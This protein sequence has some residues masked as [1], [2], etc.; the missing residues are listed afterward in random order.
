[1]S[2]PHLDDGLPAD[3]LSRVL[4][5]GGQPLLLMPDYC[6]ATLPGRA[7]ICWKDT[8]ASARAVTAALPLLLRA[9]QVLLV[10]VDEGAGFAEA[11]IEAM[12]HRLG[13]HG[14]TAECLR[15]SHTGQPVMDAL[16]HSA[17]EHHADLL[18]MGCYGHGALRRLLLGGC[19][20]SVLDHA[21]LP[22]LLAR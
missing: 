1:M 22:V 6:P 12:Q 19:T 21:E 10:C 5:D 9:Q 20:Q 14:I 13:R 11:S 8:T 18:V 4:Q 2:R 15:I 7:M 17:Q 16:R 3:V